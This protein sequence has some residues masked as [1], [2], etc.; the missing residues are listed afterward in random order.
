MTPTTPRRSPNRKRRAR[1][2]RVL[3]RPLNSRAPCPRI[4]PALRTKKSEARPRL[5][6][7][8]KFSTCL[9]L[10]NHHRHDRS[11]LSVAVLPAFTCIVSKMNIYLCILTTNA[12]CMTSFS[13]S[14]ASHPESETHEVCPAQLCTTA[15]SRNHTATTDCSTSYLWG[16]SSSS[17]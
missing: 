14:L 9:T 1:R 11:I 13:C 7:T 15:G 17:H 5:T 10:P 3:R 4:V 12:F 8:R 6:R 16:F 2:A